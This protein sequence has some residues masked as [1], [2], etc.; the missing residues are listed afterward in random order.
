MSNKHA[1]LSWA[2][3]MALM[4]TYSPSDEQVCN[5]FGLKTE[6]L[7]MARNLRTQGVPLMQPSATFDVIRYGNPFQASS[8][9]ESVT[10]KGKSKATIHTKPATLMATN[11]A[12][13]PAETKTKKA[14]IALKRGRKGDK[15]QQALLAVPE[16]PISVDDFRK[17]HGISLAVL[18]QSKRFVSKMEMSVQ[19][20]IG[21]VKVRQ[22]K[23]TKVLMIWREL[24]K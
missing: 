8:L 13:L 9:V 3:R 7:D 12:L 6:E 5:L 2:E 16:T 24:T 19:K 22:D 14:K 11:E 21:T 17:Q 4:D 18:R 10:K 1:T 15:I 20:Q 23:D